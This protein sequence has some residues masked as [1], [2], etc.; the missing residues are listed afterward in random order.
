MPCRDGRDDCGISTRTH[1]Q[2]VNRLD[3][4]TQ[5]LCFLCG[6]VEY[7]QYWETIENPRLKKWW[8]EHQDSDRKRVQKEIQEMLK[9][10][11]DFTAARVATFLINAAVKVH[12]VSEWHKK[13]FLV[14]AEQGITWFRTEEARLNRLHNSIVKKLSDTEVDF[15][16]NGGLLTKT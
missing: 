9:H 4:V 5:N 2:V 12:P 14:L 3:E 11:P 1:D 15:I 7:R 10:N 6:E 13:W 8:R 16:K